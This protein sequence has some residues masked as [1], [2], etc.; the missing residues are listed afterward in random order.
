MRNFLKKYV[1]MY[2][3]SREINYNNKYIDEITAMLMEDDELW[4]TMDNIIST[5]VG[6]EE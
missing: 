6:M 2:L 5:Y 1:K 3:S 4:N